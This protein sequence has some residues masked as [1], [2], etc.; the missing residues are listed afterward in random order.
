MSSTKTATGFYKPEI[1]IAEPLIVDKALTNYPSRLPD[2]VKVRLKEAAVAHQIAVAL[3]KNPNA[4]FREL[5]SNECRASRT[6]IK[7]YEASPRIEVTLIPSIRRLIMEGFDS[8]GIT[9]DVFVD[10][11]R[12]MGRTTN[13]EGDEVGQF[14][15][16][17]FSVFTLAD[18]IK[19]ET[20]ARETGER[21]GVTATNAT[22]F[23][24]LPDEEVS[25]DGYGTCITMQL[26]PDIKLPELV[27][28][29]KKCCR[30][31]DIETHLHVTE[32]FV[33]KD[34]KWDWVE[35]KLEVEHTRLDGSIRH[36]VASYLIKTEGDRIIYEVEI[37]QPAYYFYGAIAG[38]DENYTC[39]NDK[40]DIRLLNVPITATTNTHKKS[41]NCKAPM[42][43]PFSCWVLN[44]K[45]ERVYQ[46][47]PDRDRF[48]DG[49]LD[50]IFA[51]IQAA[52]KQKLSKDFN[53]TS[54]EDYRSS[55]WKGIYSRPD[56][57][58]RD[59]YLDDKT[60]HLLRILAL[61]VVHPRE[62]ASKIEEDEF[63]GR[64]RRWQYT[65]S[66]NINQFSKTTK[67]REIKIEPIRS[68]IARSRNIFFHQ[69]PVRKDGAKSIPAKRMLELR[70]ILRTQYPDAE[71]VTLDS[72]EAAMVLTNEKAV[73]TDTRQAV[74]GIKKQLGKD[75]RK[76]CG[77]EDAKAR[78]PDPT[79]WP[80]HRWTRYRV[81]PERVKVNKLGSNTLRVP[82]RVEQLIHALKLT[83]TKYAVTK[84]HP[85]LKGGIKLQDFVKTVENNEVLTKAGSVR[86]R[87]LTNAGR[88]GI[89]VTDKPEIL[90][91]YSREDEQSTAP[92]ASI[93]TLVAAEGDTVFQIV[94]YLEAKNVEYDTLWQP[95]QDEYKSRTGRDTIP[96]DPASCTLAYIGAST[97]KTEELLE[98]FLN[99]AEEQEYHPS[100]VDRYLTLTRQL[101]TEIVAKTK[102]QQDKPN[103][104]KV[105]GVD[106]D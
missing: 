20:L 101:D 93:K 11:L 60:K 7:K 76:R 64:Y 47:T 39:D 38:N 74:E 55:T 43:L 18:S 82:R 87:D 54:I 67:T 2:V 68:V 99:A 44:I 27:K 8:M 72:N 89:Y 100:A 103:N 45:D 51:E 6:A 49:A 5:F 81:E 65:G 40:H 91:V 15:W 58:D 4:G 92:S 25:K 34:P 63:S 94:A 37:S 85:K 96:S 33:V 46:P 30:Y 97:I 3:Y 41:W 90:Q 35:S 16:G 32:K 104:K 70:T 28:Y 50:G 17:F 56:H 75:W 14:G 83:R 26:K 69:G 29:M 106:H 102:D 57:S 13:N 79:D 84:D 95:T 22:A 53:I 10:V 23:K 73:R 71:V 21:Y 105:R 12:W 66:G 1:P 48:I 31:S 36:Q 59:E 86:F 9:S 80:V 98:L 77:L 62:P 88:I 19:L 61:E 78:K 52:L 24:L 42:E